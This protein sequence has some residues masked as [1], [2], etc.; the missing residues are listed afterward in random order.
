LLPHT[1]HKE[2][3]RLK[4]SL[5]LHLPGLLRHLSVPGDTAG[6]KDNIA[7]QALL[8]EAV[9]SGGEMPDYLL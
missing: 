4:L 3:Q 7:H 1:N 5:F 2:N 8:Y 9:A 6:L